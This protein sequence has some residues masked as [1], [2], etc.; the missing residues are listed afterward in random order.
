VA[1]RA[2]SKPAADVIG[3]PF[4]SVGRLGEDLKRRSTAS[5]IKSRNARY[6]RL[7]DG[8]MECVRELDKD[9][10][11][12]VPVLRTPYLRSIKVDIGP[13]GCHLSAREVLRRVQ[14]RSGGDARRPG[15]D[16][17]SDRRD[18][19]IGTNVLGCWRR[20]VRQHP[21]RACG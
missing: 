10:L 12:S 16:G 17:E 15:D 5:T 8:S 7:L 1:A 3:Q 19:E 11:G 18:L 14:T 6:H 21:Q 13:G 20:E 2:R 4:D 9:G